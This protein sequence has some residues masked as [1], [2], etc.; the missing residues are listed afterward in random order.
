LFGEAGNDEFVIRAFILKNT[1][2]TATTDTLASGGA[3]DDHYEYN[4]NAPVNIDGGDGVDTVVVIGTEV[5]DNFVITKD[6]VQ[7]AG[8]NVSFLNVERVD[9][10]GLEGDDHFYVLSTSPKVVTT[11]IGGLGSDTVDVGG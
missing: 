11:I 2:Q 9:V 3:G 5:A 7:G 1:N 10:D 4:I 8:L 6:G